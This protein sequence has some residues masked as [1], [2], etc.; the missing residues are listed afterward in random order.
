MFKSSEAE[1]TQD[2]MITDIVQNHCTMHTLMYT[3]SYKDYTVHFK[4]SK[5]VI[6]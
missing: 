1:S 6:S 3:I 4:A 5:H 2:L